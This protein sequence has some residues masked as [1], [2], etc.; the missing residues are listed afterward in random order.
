[1]LDKQSPGARSANRRLTHVLAS[2]PKDNVG[3][4]YWDGVLELGLAEC[5]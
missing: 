5:K 2:R 1:M 3:K 4:W